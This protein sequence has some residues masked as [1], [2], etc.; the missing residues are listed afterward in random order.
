MT[1][2]QAVFNGK[3]L[4]R[5]AV[6]A[7]ALLA[8]TAAPAN[9]SQKQEAVEQWLHGMIQNAIMGRDF[10]WL[11]TTSQKFRT[12]KQRMP[13]GRWSLERFYY[14]L[15]DHCGM[16]SKEQVSP[17]MTEFYAKWQ[18]EYPKSPAPS[19]ILASCHYAAAMNLRGKGYA[20]EVWQD[21][22]APMIEKLEQGLAIL[23]KNKA[24]A[25]HD[26]HWY[27]VKSYMQ[28]HLN[29]P[30]RVFAENIEE[31][32]R[33]EP[34]YYS[35]YNARF[36]RLLPR[37]GGSY[38]LAERWARRASA[39]TS[40]SYGDAIYAHMALRLRTM[41]SDE[42][43]VRDY[44]FDWSRLKKGMLDLFTTQQTPDFNHAMDFV[45]M[46]C[47]L[48]DVEHA[49]KVWKVWQASMPD[50]PDFKAEVH[51]PKKKLASGPRP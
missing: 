51:C 4:R 3:M 33:V 15:Q 11:E 5:A 35:H 26:P 20:H 24:L 31:A 8:A 30:D 14:I 18:A 23:E 46:S 38:A 34:L 50:T 9:A 45:E 1:N 21:A 32:I 41:H 19:I 29:V 49:A 6:A 43:I 28:L 2:G 36:T 40:A 12:E 27:A 10:A 44:K 37:W 16:D 22:W 39:R 25:G 48:R 13:S 47:A 17:F 42:E 7:L